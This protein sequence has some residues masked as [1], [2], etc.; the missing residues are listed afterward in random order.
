MNDLPEIL[1]ARARPGRPSLRVRCECGSVLVRIWYSD[2]ST[3]SE[4]AHNAESVGNGKRFVCRCRRAYLFADDYRET[5]DLA[6]QQAAATGIR[7]LFMDDL[8]SQ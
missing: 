7:D 1:K 5:L 2:G 4:W 6:V 3:A 8:I